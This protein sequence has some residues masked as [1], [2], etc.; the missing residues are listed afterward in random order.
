MPTAAFRGGC[1]TGPLHAAAELH[2]FLGYLGKCVAMRRRYR[3]F[4]Y[5]AKQVRDNIHAR[6]LIGAFDAFR[7]VPRAGEVYN[8]GGGPQNNISMLEAIAAFEEAT[9]HRALVEYI[10]TPR[11]GDHIWYVSDLTKFETHYPAW[12][13]KYSMTDIIQEIAAAASATAA[14]ETSA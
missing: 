8:I 11:K 1:L 12:S 3:V 10:D 7:R 14:K 6:D 2:G 4:G 5:K 9:G 13:Q